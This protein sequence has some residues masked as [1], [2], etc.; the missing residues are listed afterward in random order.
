MDI[1]YRTPFHLTGEVCDLDAAQGYL[2]EDDMTEYLKEDLDD[3]CTYFK[4]P[5]AHLKDKVK[6]IEWHLVT[7]DEGYIEL[8]ATEEIPQAELDQISEWVS[9]QC[10]DGLGEG[11][12][13]QDFANYEAGNHD[14][15]GGDYEDEDWD[16]DD[17]NDGWTMC[18][19]DWKTNKYIFSRYEA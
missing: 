14:S 17:E 19:F 13:Q 3:S 15:W 12:E 11:F 18:S 9:G 7:E 16:A 2:T 4:L 5:M 8:I 1:K 10:S 6:H